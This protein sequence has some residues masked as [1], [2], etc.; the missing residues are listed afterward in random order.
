VDLSDD[1]WNCELEQVIW[2]NVKAQDTNADIMDQFSSL[3][4]GQ[5]SLL[6][7]SNGEI[8]AVHWCV[9]DCMYKIKTHRL[10]LEL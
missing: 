1:Q 10:L 9:E 6:R 5:P 8:L 4:F 3:K 7:L 2:G